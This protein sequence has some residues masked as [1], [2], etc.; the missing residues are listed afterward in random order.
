MLLINNSGFGTYGPFPEPNLSNTL[1]MIDVNVRAITQLTGLLLPLLKSRGG[2]IVNVAS[3]AAFMP[4]AYT[5]AYAAS[6]AYVLH[7]SLALNEELHGSGV[8]V[9]AFCPG[10][11]ATA[12]FERAGVKPAAMVGRVS[13]TSDDV[14]V[15]MVRAMG[16]NSPVAVSGFANKIM[17][18]VCGKLSKPLATG[19]AGKVMARYWHRQV[20]G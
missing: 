3:T 9:L 10:T 14:A 1:E 11:T 17:V 18:G 19:L 12:F 20:N 7:W 8:R 4:V 15:A 16:K 5:A 13:Q 6:K 2:M